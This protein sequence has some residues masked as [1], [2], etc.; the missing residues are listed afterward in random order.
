MRKIPASIALARAGRALRDAEISPEAWPQ[1]LDSLMDA[2]S[3]AGAACILFNNQT[4]KADWVCFSGLSAELETRYIDHYAAL[5]PFSPLLKADPGW[6]QLLRALPRSAL[7]KSEWYNDFVLGCGVRDMMGASLVNSPSHSCI[8]GLHQQ[9]GRNSVSVDMA[10]L[11]KL[12]P[13]LVS[14]TLGQ[15]RRLPTAAEIPSNETPGRIARVAETTTYFFHI[16][17]GRRYTDESGQ[18]FYS[19]DDAIAHAAQL[20]LEL[21]RD[22]GWQ[23]FSVHM[24]DEDGQLIVQKPVV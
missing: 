24:T 15:I 20:A 1:A 12:T 4:G 21:S 3:L 11:D 22:G 10:A 13:S 19:R 9:I 5:D 18:R 17:N 7:A 16:C 23:G 8:F 6:K 2:L 14:A